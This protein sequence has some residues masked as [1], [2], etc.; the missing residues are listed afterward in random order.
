MSE[1]QAPE[2]RFW[3]ASRVAGAVLLGCV[4][5]FALAGPLLVRADPA[6]QD[7]L[8]A[9]ARPSLAE[10]LGTDALGRSMIARLTSAARLSLGL[11]L[12]TVVSAAIP[13]TL[14]GIVAAWWGGWPERVLVALA[15]S[16]LA[17]PAILLLLL[18]VAIV[19]G[20]FWPLYLGLALSLWVEYF[21]VVR[22]GARTVLRSPQVEASRLLGFG[23]RYV[24]RRHLLPA[25]L[26]TILTLMSYGA[27]TVVL[28]LATLGFIGVGLRPPTA[29]LGL[30]MTELL[31]FYREAPWLLAA[32]I[33][34][35]TVTVLALALLTG[36]RGR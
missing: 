12:L 16:I 24:V 13:G 7:L 15:D 30:M 8:H 10:P 6:A 9:L 29:E 28:A 14:L 19:P 36:E 1:G 32:P 20:S 4:A 23:R 5:T 33:V 22:L 31:P 18:L 25:L 35:L 26:P 2:A 27:A 3:S 11:A 34:V 17:V 21:R